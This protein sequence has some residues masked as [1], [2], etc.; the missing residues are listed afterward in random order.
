MAWTRWLFALR[1]WFQRRRESLTLRRIGTR[2]RSVEVLEQRELLS[3]V[4]PIP[5]VY[6]TK[7]GQT[8]VAT[9]GT[10][11]N[12]DVTLLEAVDAP[13]NVVQMEY[14]DAYGLLIVRNTG[15]QVTVVDPFT[16][17]VVDRHTPT[18]TFS[19]MDLT[20]D[21][22]YLFVA[23]YGGEQTGYSRPANTHY[24]HR[25]DLKTRLWSVHAAP[26]TVHKIEAVDA[27]HYLAQ[28]LDQHVE[29]MFNEFTNEREVS[30]I[31]ADYY[32][33]FEYDHRT[34][35]VYHGSSGS[36]SSEIHVRTL[37][38]ERLIDSG[39]TGVYGT[40]QSGG[41]G[42]VL[43]SDGR[44][45]Y[46]GRLQVDAAN[47][48]TNLRTFGEQI[49]A[50]TGQIAFGKIGYYNAENGN[51]LGSLGFQATVYAVSDDGVH[52]WAYD[53]TTAKINHYQI[54]S[55][56][57]GVLANDA[58]RGTATAELTQGPRRGVLSLQTDGGFTYTPYAGYV[59][60]DTFQ[61]R[62]AN[63]AERSEVTTV[64]ITIP[65]P[66]ERPAKGLP[67]EY[68]IFAGQTL[69]TGVGV[70]QFDALGTPYSFAVGNDAVQLEYSAEFNLLLARTTTQ[71]RVYDGTSGQLISTR[72]AS[73]NFTDMD[74]TPD[75]RFLFVA[76]YGGVAT[77]YGTPTRQHYAHRFDLANRTWDQRPA[78]V[79]YRIEGVN[80]DLYLAQEIDQHVD[81]MLNSF[82]AAS[83]LSRVRADYYGD[84]EYDH[85]TGRVY[86]GSSGSSS[87]EI[88]VRKINGTAL[89]SV[90][91]TGVYGTAQSG[92]GSSVLSSNG[93]HFYYGKL[94]VEAADVRNNL[95]TF[96]EII[97]AA[98]GHVAFGNN[99][100]YD[101]TTG[102]KLGSLGFTTEVLFVTDDGRHL[103][104]KNGAQAVHYE[105]RT[106]PAGL[107]ANDLGIS[108]ATHR[109]RTV[110][111]P[112]HGTVTV[113]GNGQIQYTPNPGYVGDDQFLYRGT[114]VLGR[115]TISTVTIHVLPPR[116]VANDDTLSADAGV[117]LLVGSGTGL[118]QNDR[119]R[120]P[121][122]AKV[123]L[124]SGPQHGVL[125]LQPNGAL[126][127]TPELSFV[128]N[129]TFRYRIAEGSETSDV[130]TVTIGVSSSVGS[131]AFQ[132]QDGQ[133]TVTM[134]NESELVVEV[135]ASGT[136]RFLTI[137]E[138]HRITQ[139]V[140]L[141]GTDF[142]QVERVLVQ[143]SEQA[144]EIDLRQMTRAVFPNL[145]TVTILGGGGDDVIQGTEL[146][147]TIEGGEGND[148]I[149]A[150]EGNDR[151]TGGTGLGNDRLDGGVGADT[152]TGG[153][154]RDTL[155]GGAD[156]DLLQAGDA[157]VFIA[158]GSGQQVL[159]NT[160]W[161]ATEIDSLEGTFVGVEL[162]GIH[163]ADLI[164][165]SAWTLGGVTVNA[166][167][168]ND[169]VI[170]SAQADS[171]L[172]GVGR[173]SIDGRD[174]ND[175]IVGG[176]GIDSLRGGNGHDRL[177][178]EGDDDVLDGE[179]GN[180]TLIGGHK[181]DLLRGGDGDDSLL[182]EFDNDTLEGDA[183]Q[184]TLDGGEEQDTL[185]GGV[186]NDQLLGNIGA[187]LLQGDAGNDRLDGGGDNDTLHGGDGNDQL[188]G[189]EGGD[190]LQGGNGQ[191]SLS[192]AAGDD[193]FDDSDGF[194]WYESVS[195]S[196]DLILDR[197]LSRTFGR[198][199]MVGSITQ[200]IMAGD[201]RDNVLDARNFPWTVSLIGGGGQDTLL[202]PDDT[203]TTFAAQDDLFQISSGATLSVSVADGVLANDAGVMSGLVRA[204]VVSMPTNGRLT[205]RND[206]S[207]EYVPNSNSTGQDSFRYRIHAFSQV[208]N[209]ATASIATL[210]ERFV[211]AGRRLE[212]HMR[213]D[214]TL[215][216]MMVYGSYRAVLQEGDEYFQ[217]NVALDSGQLQSLV[218]FGSQG[219]DVIDLSSLDT[220]RVSSL[221]QI[222]IQGGEGDDTITGSLLNE[223]ILGG[224]GN[225]SIEAGDGRD[226][227]LGGD[228]NDDLDGGD[229]N[230][231]LEAGAGDDQIY[232]G[233]G[234]DTSVGQAGR[235]LL[236]A[237]PGKDVLRAGEKSVVVVGGDLNWVLTNKSVKA[238]FVFDRR[239]Y[240]VGS[241]LVGAFSGALVVGGD[242][243]NKYDASAFRFGNVIMTGGY[244][245]DTLIGSP[246]A[247]LLIGEEGQ[248]NLD[249][250]GG[251]DLL[252][253]EY[254][255]D[256]L[257]G[258][259]GDD[260]LFGESGNDSLLGD[261]GKDSLS[262]GLGDDIFRDGNGILWFEGTEDSSDLILT[263]NGIQGHGGDRFINRVTSLVLFGD[264]GDNLIDASAYRA[265]GVTIDADEGNDT[266]IGTSQNDVIVGGE[267]D[268][269]LEGR[270]GKD[271]LIGSSGDDSLN[272]EAGNDTLLGEAGRDVLI[273][274]ADSDLLLGGDDDDTL[275][276]QAQR[277]TL[278]GGTGANTLD[279]NAEQNERATF[280]VK[281]AT[282][283]LQPPQ[284]VQSLNEL[285]PEFDDE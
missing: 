43:S 233:D 131:S 16:D 216:F 13:G 108:L 17:S 30:R 179:S 154:G 120:F 63:G 195:T 244:G 48:R 250:R 33:D 123:Q 274:G 80:E 91:D 58:G 10:S 101:A 36:S 266:V 55:R 237:S 240:T 190:S 169:T 262:G 275:Q 141:I 12:L 116:L 127:Y 175:T 218:I 149:E 261:A 2:P 93:Q 111:Q 238:T 186:G 264:E 75:G 192:G 231:S 201:E 74:L 148:A 171:L 21:G 67:D 259:T 247:D 114:G 246:G 68:S 19:D 245:N 59:G 203:T 197:D 95:R 281:P 79:V 50:A 272:A 189:N 187:D 124:V 198:D 210:P 106:L 196:P 69:N 204:E 263:A 51:Y 105:I 40:A 255:N 158:S 139:R 66:E 4:S 219:G 11:S 254:G 152:L 65:Q 128:G 140:S 54:G 155:L 271:L 84:F 5:D 284:L 119:E 173:D 41:G 256:T 252:N 185:R 225:D 92:G 113:Q 162:R 213:R 211:T 70:E 77:G 71:I 150:G 87:S 163:T 251:N 143:G 52:V 242:E 153:S 214:S 6:Q 183:G 138:S 257:R 42:S 28:E 130:A 45:F 117:E 199:T 220:S 178:G 118:M 207:F 283:S 29:M 168:G 147:D 156:N 49:Y 78:L 191:D 161:Q 110:T 202:F 282:A 226:T 39:D 53:S 248:D 170:G 109:A 9:G 60:D 34:G 22:R 236:V 133:L 229:G 137:R 267:G 205:F 151:V 26:W 260:T 145:V 23:D 157:T 212:I 270:E 273:G 18:W 96:P 98:T 176:D 167:A 221:S 136:Q 160:Q 44:R 279:D 61:Y 200:I 100:Y 174:A 1:Y 280:D 24:V 209:V 188:F 8:L 25:F 85:R 76:D 235:D 182:G 258:N 134:P 20:P 129:D 15:G 125:T 184:D 46:Y 278:A 122:S 47:V 94:Q 64:T 228:G 27:E 115:S 223:S 31:R 7:F 215:E 194:V 285:I 72:P 224:A 208:S 227:V 126:S 81:M 253:G 181:R 32:G 159:T 234:D 230:D 243:D 277:D 177:D 164:D 38:G 276:G 107:Y 56:P 99:S 239:R 146:A 104:V 97:R 265:S 57:S 112:E 83:E 241:T 269:V 268:D 135:P 3:V 86:H 88:H 102:Q 165:A 166:G 249:G 217:S 73:T 90:G 222:T 103:W 82:A 35:R 142:E 144:D 121:G 132:L 62:L 89:T 14:S 37:Q 193:R 172:G 180:D 206:G 232:G